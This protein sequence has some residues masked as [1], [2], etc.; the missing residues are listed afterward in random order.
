EHRTAATIDDAL[1]DRYLRR[2]GIDDRP[3]PT[4][5]NLARLQESHVLTVP[6]ENLDYHY[7]REIP[8]DE[9]IVTKIVDE[10]RGGGCYELNPSFHHLLRALGYDSRIM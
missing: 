9:R 10:K 2:L 4:L 3:E 8:M 7:G 1:V 6:F 5:D